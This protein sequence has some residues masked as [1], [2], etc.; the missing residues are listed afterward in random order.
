[1]GYARLLRPIVY[2]PTE[3]SRRKRTS[4]RIPPEIGKLSVENL[5]HLLVVYTLEEEAEIQGIICSEVAKKV[6]FPWRFIH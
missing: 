1:M 4:E 3:V 5:G 2:D 6:S